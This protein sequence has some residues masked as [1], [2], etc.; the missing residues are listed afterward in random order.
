[1]IARDLAV[2][3]KA[4]DAES[5]EWLVLNVP[6]L[7]DALRV[8]VERGASAVEIRRFVVRYAGRVQLAQRLEQA[9]AYLQGVEE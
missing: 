9:A 5:W 4:I 6:A 7:A 1:M 3:K 2:L 8:E